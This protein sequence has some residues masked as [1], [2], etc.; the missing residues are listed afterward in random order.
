MASLEVVLL[1]GWRGGCVIAFRHLDGDSL[2]R[3]EKGGDLLLRDLEGQPTQFDERRVAGLMEWVNPL[4][5][6]AFALETGRG[7]MCGDKEGCFR[8]KRVWCVRLGR[9]AHLADVGAAGADI[10]GRHPLR[11]L[12]RD[13]RGRVRVIVFLAR[14][15][16]PQRGLLDEHHRGGNL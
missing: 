4:E 6:G 5:K 15:V 14:K 11:Q 13:S 3:L 9:V 8:E 1:L 16:G 2:H 7:N 12:V 10:F